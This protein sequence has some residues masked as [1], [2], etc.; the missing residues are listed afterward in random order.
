MLLTT[1]DLSDIEELC[2]RIM[3]IDKG[4]LLFDGP[5]AVMKQRLAKFNQIKFFLGTAA[6]WREARPGHASD[7]I[8][9]RARG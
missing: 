4:R 6:R 5:L 3:I 9:V 8:S 2:K 1:H 7:G